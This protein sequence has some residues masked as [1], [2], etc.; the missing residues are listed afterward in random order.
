MGTI[1]PA[2]AAVTAPC[3]KPAGVFPIQSRGNH[4]T[5]AAFYIEVLRQADKLDLLNR[6]IL[7]RI[8]DG[9]YTH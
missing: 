9:S 2:A 1:L 4:R 3:V 8:G 5:Q 7:R 6:D